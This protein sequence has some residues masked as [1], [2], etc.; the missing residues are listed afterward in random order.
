MA[1]RVLI[2]REVPD[3]VNPQLNKLL[4]KMRSLAVQQP[5]YISGETLKKVSSHHIHLVISS[6]KNLDDWEGWLALK[7]RQETQAE[8]D[9]L[10][11][12]ETT[13]EVFHH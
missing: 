1:V 9:L 4:I 3:K 2:H 7:E 13:Y 8:I 5:G 6:W 10:L 12:Q 11:G